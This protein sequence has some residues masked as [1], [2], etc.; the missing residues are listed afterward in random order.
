MNQRGDTDK[1][2]TQ[3]PDGKPRPHRAVPCL[4]DGEALPAT[5]GAGVIRGFGINQLARQP[6]GFAVTSRAPT[7]TGVCVTFPPG[8]RM[9]RA[10]S[11][12]F[13]ANNST[14]LSCESQPEPA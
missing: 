6:Y 11:G 14:A 8:Q 10:E 9:E 7:G 13:V 4:L 12:R 3:S 1:R 2:R 5:P